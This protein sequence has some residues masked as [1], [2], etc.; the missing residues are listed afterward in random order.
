[1]AAVRNTAFI[2]TPFVIFARVSVWRSSLEYCDV[3][4]LP[5]HFENGRPSSRAKAK[6]I[7]LY[8]T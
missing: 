7:L 1:M 8:D 2:G 3:L 6:V 5:I 4:A